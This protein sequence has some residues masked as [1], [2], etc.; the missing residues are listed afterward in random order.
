MNS[1]FKYFCFLMF[2]FLVSV[3]L[4]KENIYAQELKLSTSEHD[5]LLSVARQYI[6]NV[7]FCSLIT[8]DSTGYPHARTMDP[9][10]PNENWVV[11][12]GTNPKSRKVDEIRN[13][14]K[15]TLY[16]TGNKGEGYVTIIGI[17]SLV[18]DQSIKDSLWKDEW[19][20]FYKDQKESYLLI[21]V[22]PKKL[23]ILDYKHGILGNKETWST[24]SVTF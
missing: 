19:S 12:F 20:R 6:K 9:F 3:Y 17:A 4:P 13:N 7:R 8:I 2:S 10:Q 14:P 15:V 11:W 21:K 16:Y 22:V 24:P 1:V 5:T 18:N 23:E